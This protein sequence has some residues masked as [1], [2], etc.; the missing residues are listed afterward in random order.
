MESEKFA[1]AHACSVMS[2]SLQHHRLAK[3]LCP[4]NFPGKNARVSGH[5]LLQENLP[6]PRI[7]SASLASPAVASRIRQPKIRIRDSPGGP[8][9]KTLPSSAEGV[10]SIPGQGTKITHTFLAKKSEHKK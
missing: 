5:F 3:F 4:W 6:D 10:G 2:N 7:E 1:G 8:V 9:V